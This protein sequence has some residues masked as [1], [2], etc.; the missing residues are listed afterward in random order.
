[1]ETFEQCSA[2]IAREAAEDRI[3]ES[4]RRK[5]ILIKVICNECQKKFQCGP[6]ASP[7]C[8]RCGGTDI[9]VSES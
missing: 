1:M 4:A 8:P 5:R 7:E 9:E 3:E 6:N 2:R